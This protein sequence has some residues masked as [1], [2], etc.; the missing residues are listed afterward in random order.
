[1]NRKKRNTLDSA[2]AQAVW[3]KADDGIRVTKTFGE[4]YP[5][6]PI[7]LRDIRVDTME[8]HVFPKGTKRAIKKWLNQE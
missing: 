2:C 8:L 7:E 6:V 5:D 1:M 4:M 3:N